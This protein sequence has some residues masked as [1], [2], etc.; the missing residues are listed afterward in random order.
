MDTIKV[1]VIN[2]GT[3]PIATERYDFQSTEGDKAKETILSALNRL[4]KAAHALIGFKGKYWV[5]D[6]T[7]VGNT[8]SKGYYKHQVKYHP[9]MKELV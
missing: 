3:T 7:A 1:L 4:G 5:A 6:H 2:S 9:F 8:P